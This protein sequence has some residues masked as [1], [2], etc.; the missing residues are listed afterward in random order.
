M[1]IHGDLN[2]MSLPDLLQWAAMT[3]K[4]GVM[5]LERNKV[6]RRI[7][8]RKGWIR[9]CSSSD[10][11]SL[12]GQYLLARGKI[13]QEQLREA[14]AEQEKSG[15][16]LGM[17]FVAM[18]AIGQ[19]ELTRQV[20]SKAEDTIQGLF[21]WEDAIFRF[22][23]GATLEPNQIEVSLSVRD[24]LFRGLQH[25][26]EL[27]EMRKSLKSSG[28]V[29]QRT[30]EP[31]PSELVEKPIAR[32][33]FESVDG[34]RT[35][36][37][38]L[39]H[40][41][42][43]DFLVIKLLYSLYRKGYLGITGERSV[44][45]RTLL[46][47]PEPVAAPIEGSMGIGVETEDEAQDPSRW[48]DQRPSDA[49]RRTAQDEA[50]DDLEDEIKV[51]SRL[52]ARGEIEVALEL[53]NASY[54]ANPTEGFLR[55]L[56]SRAEAAYVDTS[57]KNDLSGDKIPVLVDPVPA[58]A[59]RRLGSEASFLKSLIDGKTDIKGILW[60]APLREVDGLR[61]LQQ[62]LDAGL[63]E[64]TDPTD[65]PDAEFSASSLSESTY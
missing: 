2:T 16:H 33:I 32:R 35:I 6:C 41:H 47:V 54:R 4:S 1:P 13:T 40:A 62:M 7:E 27:K 61:A 48:R 9:A 60:V 15:T 36:E 63:I 5:E 39:L 53:L 49:P 17:I 65:T 64:L 31:V 22:H 37:E 12:L 14:L 51:A 34:E 23:E 19:P 29:L 26:D 28:I 38:I 44:K 55:E 30:D 3:Q 24:I 46:D 8:F 10:P 52:M 18:G 56:I 57:R 58:E 21:D 42:A 11:S 50:R 43:S 59:G 45:T 25:H 20:I